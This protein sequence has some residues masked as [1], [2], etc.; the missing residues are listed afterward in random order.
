LGRGED[1]FV[2]S[3]WRS[4]LLQRRKSKRKMR[5]KERRNIKTRQLKAGLDGREVIFDC[6]NRKR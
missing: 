6:G 3:H 5:G 4:I 1:R 2:R